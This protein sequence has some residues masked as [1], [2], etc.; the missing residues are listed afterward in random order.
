MLSH[1]YGRLSLFAS[2]RTKLWMA[3][4]GCRID[5]HLLAK[6]RK[7]LSLYA[8]CLIQP[9]CFAL[10]S[11]W[12]LPPPH[13]LARVTL[14]C[15][16]IPLC[17]RAKHVPTSVTM[18][19]YPLEARSRCEPSARRVQPPRELSRKRTIS[20]MSPDMIRSPYLSWTCSCGGSP[21]IVKPQCCRSVDIRG[22][23]AMRL[24]LRARSSC[25]WVS[26][27]SGRDFAISDCK[28]KSL[29]FVMLPSW[30]VGY[31]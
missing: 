3:L 30:F 15:I 13:L 17:S 14:K 31:W 27:N 11:W 1:C 16:F 4:V 24:T 29:G 19:L 6:V 9:S 22:H 12:Q 5:D 8:L 28:F 23:S 18:I 20:T 25:C 21:G 7:C 26:H 10:F 2:S